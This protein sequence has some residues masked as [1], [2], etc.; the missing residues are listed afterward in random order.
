MFDL[1]LQLF[2]WIN[3]GPQ[4][5]TLLLWLA[6][7]SSTVLP[8]A[9]LVGVCAALWLR[10]PRVRRAM[11]VA[12]LA[13]AL[14]WLVSRGLSTLWPTQRPF[15]LSAGY[16]WLEHKPT[17]SFPSSHASAAFGMGFS[18]WRRLRGQPGRWLPLVVAG[19]VG[20]SRV[21][22]GLHFPLD[23]VAGLGVGYLSS[24]LACRLLALLGGDW[25]LSPAS[26]SQPW[27]ARGRPGG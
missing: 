26:A 11:T 18:S 15:A 4:S 23:V 20:W 24:L 14:A 22:L 17:S 5:H 25:V 13:M 19:L 12:L 2:Q 16:Q 8:S 9:A 10:A 1:N 3:L 21:A 7:V 27:A 6:R